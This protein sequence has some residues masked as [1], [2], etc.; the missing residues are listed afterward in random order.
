MNN[1]KANSFKPLSVFIICTLLLGAATITCAQP[2]QGKNPQEKRERI[3]AMKIGFI[4]EKL[5]LTTEEAQ[6][7]WPVYI[8]FQSEM[9]VIKKDRRESF[10]KS[11]ENFDSLS[12]KDIEKFVDQQVV[13]KQMELDV[14]RK[15]LAEF[16]QVL[17]MKKVAQL[18]KAEEDFKRQLLK[19]AQERR[20]NEQNR[21]Y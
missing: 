11:R 8:E 5:S 16:K 17:P 12:D 1:K 20:K 3:E 10:K 13:F 15:Y 2:S 4:T 6:I 7:F 14:D 18:Y 9:H 21:S 19:A